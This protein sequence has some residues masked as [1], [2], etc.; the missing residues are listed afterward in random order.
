MAGMNKLEERL[1]IYGAVLVLCGI[2]AAFLGAAVG[3]YTFIQIAAVI[4]FTY[5]FGSPRRLRP[6]RRF[7]LN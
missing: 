3:L 5:W 4:E 1:L 2:A 6:G 7:Q